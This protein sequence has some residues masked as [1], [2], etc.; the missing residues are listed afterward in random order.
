MTDEEQLV[1][2]TEQQRVIYS[3]NIG[4][5]C[6]LHSDFMPQER[7]HAGIIL[8][9]QQQYSIGQQVRGLLKIAAVQS[10]ETI[11]NQLIF[12]TGYIT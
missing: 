12:L 3:F 5:F 2:A 1:W 7:V 11:Q 10:T 4:D 9:R 6:R 8:A